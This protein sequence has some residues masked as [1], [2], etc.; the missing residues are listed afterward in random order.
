MFLFEALFKLF[1]DMYLNILGFPDNSAGIES[2]LQCRIQ[3]FDCWVMKFPWRQD[4]LP[5][6]V[7]SGFPGGSDGKQSAYNV[8]DLG[9]W[10]GKIMAAH[11]SILAW[12]I[13]MDRGAWQAI[14]HA[15]SKNQTQ[16][17]D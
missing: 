14:V 7:F 11:S 2:D 16:L 12:K 5:T 4:G 10:V 8:G 13:P 17:R 1:N 3:Q 6:P 9:S 15:V